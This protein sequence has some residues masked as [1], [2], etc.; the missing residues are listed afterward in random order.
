MN[1]D[2]HDALV[3]A[4]QGQ[5]AVVITLSVFSGPGQQE[6][7]LK[8]AA[9]ANVPW[10]LP[11]EWSPDSAHEGLTR[12]VPH[13]DD[14]P[15]IRDYIKQLG[16]SSYIA[17]SCGFWY[18]WS[19]SI[20]AAYGIDCLKQEAILFDDGETKISTTTWPQFGRAVAGLLALPIQPEDGNKDRCL[21]RF[22]NGHVYVSSFTVSQN[23][24]LD[25]AFRVTGTKKEDWKITKEPSEQRY[26]SGFEAMK[27]GDRMGFVR[28]MY[29]RVFYPDMSG[30]HEER[31]GT[32]NALLG[33]PKEDIDEATRAAI[34]RQKHS[35]W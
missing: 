29:T 26:Q 30:N 12:D 4:L 2:N 24:M 17:V 20:P 18:E 9:D 22:R 8:A 10:V 13:F 5:D 34:E 15:R 6:K 19:L 33:L 35:P 21:E 16:K 7:L 1:Y 32:V 23:D 25:S 31:M 11:N 27:G 3:D 14:M 28:A